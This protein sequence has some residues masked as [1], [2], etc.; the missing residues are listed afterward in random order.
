ML[1]SVSCARVAGVFLCLGLASH[2]TIAEPQAARVIAAGGMITETIYALGQRARLVGV[3]STSQFP[4]EAIRL[5]PN[6][7]YVRALSAEG[8]LSLKPDLVLAIESA[9]PPH[10]LALIQ[11][12]GVRLQ[13]LSDATNEAGVI[14]RIRIVGTALGANEAA[15]Q[16]AETV[17]RDFAELA[18]R[19]RRSSGEPRVLFVLSLQNGRVMVGGRNSSAAAMITL[20]G[21]RNAADAIEGYKPLSDE[22]IIAANPDVI[23]M[24]QQGDHRLTPEQVFGHPA[25]GLT[26]AAKRQALVTMDGLLLLGF[27]PRTPKA[28]RMLLDALQGH[29]SRRAGETQQPAQHSRHSP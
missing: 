22:G 19:R 14:E 15:S 17:L 25:L 12:A 24:M 7:G 13:I 9:G 21:G 28:A 20:A 23:V 8:I 2:S 11:Q 18:E 26:P 16:L 6:V 27:G 5:H 29:S 1:N 4:P 10:V 3:D